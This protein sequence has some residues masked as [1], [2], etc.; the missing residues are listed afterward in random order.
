MNL[1]P[2]CRQH[3]VELICRGMG[4][5][6]ERLDLTVHDACYAYGGTHEDETML[7]LAHKRYCHDREVT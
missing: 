1:A 6:G 2:W 3:G 4:T 7:A 5:R